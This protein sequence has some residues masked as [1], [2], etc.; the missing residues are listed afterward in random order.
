MHTSHIM[1]HR[2]WFRALDQ[3]ASITSVIQR[4]DTFINASAVQLLVLEDFR[5]ATEEAPRETLCTWP[6][7]STHQSC[8]VVHDDGLVVLYC[9]GGSAVAVSIAGHPYPRNSREFAAPQRACAPNQAPT[10]RSTSCLSLVASHAIVI[11]IAAGMGSAMR[12]P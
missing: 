10:A 12:Q 9:L 4:V 1:S 5:R 3:L 11:T 7:E 6:K 8:C 2:T